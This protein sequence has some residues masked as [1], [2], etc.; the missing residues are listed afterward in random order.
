MKCLLDTDSLREAE[1]L[2]SRLYIV[3]TD[4]LCLFF[5]GK[6]NIMESLSIKSPTQLLLQT[7]NY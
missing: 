4:I 5:R 3:L 6:Y 1:G 7:G 2:S